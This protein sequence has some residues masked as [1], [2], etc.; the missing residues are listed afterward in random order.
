MYPHQDDAL[1]EVVSG[2][3][4][5]RRLGAGQVSS[6]SSPACLAGART[7]VAA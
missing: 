4:V 7:G 6:S 5:I 3:N 1:I 2:A